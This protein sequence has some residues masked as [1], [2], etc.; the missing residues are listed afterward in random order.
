MRLSSLLFVALFAL[1]ACAPTRQPTEGPAPVPTQT[2]T[3]P[4][5]AETTPEKPS[6]RPEP[7]APTTSAAFPAMA[8]ERWWLLDP[9]TDGVIGTGTDRAYREL[10]AGKAPR[11][12]VVVAII[13]SGVDTDHPDL[14]PNLWTNT[15]EVAG[16]GK[17]DDGNGYVDDIHGWNF[18]GG[19][20]GGQVGRDTY[21]VTRL[22]A[23]Y[24]KRFANANTDTLSAAARAEYA[25]Y[26]KV[27]QAYSA[28]REEAQR[29][30][31]QVRMI[32]TAV[33]R[34]YALLQ[35]HLGTDSL[36]IERVRAINSPRMELRQA[37]QVYLELAAQSVTPAVIREEL[38]RMENLLEYGLNPEFDPRG[39][40]GDNYADPSERH[41]GNH[42]VVGPD[43][44]HGTHVAGIVGAARDNGVC[45]DGI[46]PNVR[47]M[48]IRA[49]PDGDERDKDIANAIRYAADNGAQI[50]NMSFGKGFSPYKAAVDAAV[51]YAEQKGVL[52][53]HAAGNDA[54]DLDQE[55][56]FP[57]RYFLDGDSATLWL[58]VGASSWQGP[59]QIAAPFSNYGR[60]RVH[61]F[62]P[63]HNIMAPTPNNGC[64]PLSGTSMAAPVVSGVAALIM[65]YYP[66]LGAADVRQII[67]ETATP[68]RDQMVT[69][70]GSQDEQVRFSDLSATGGVI[71][72]YQALRRAEEVAAAKRR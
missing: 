38:D 36:T 48:A 59:G 47:L 52:L 9:T 54:E 13:D 55:A 70:P 37:Q 45:T 19:K 35:Q 50:I 66:E 11:R 60:Q 44:K 51:R 58:E 18:I 33:D 24:H 28:K 21:E 67:L 26:R 69:R 1:G 5:R 71:N 6:A 2:A 27:E 64:E 40:V 34:F 8:P 43:A 65:S 32:A 7:E 16:N 46:A 63:G 41:Y 39:I 3:A 56:N 68:Y 23:H 53:V 14:A 15:R 30:L 12:S 42:D 31:Q 29:D 72:A 62:A 57:N 22:Y 10:L 61:I 20:D 4:E 17:D 49:V 25:E